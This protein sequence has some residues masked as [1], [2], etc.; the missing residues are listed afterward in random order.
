MESDKLKCFCLGLNFCGF[1]RII[2]TSCGKGGLNPNKS[3]ASPELLYIIEA[4]MNISSES[5]KSEIYLNLLLKVE[6]F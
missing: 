5:N 1:N 2:V 4:Q 3:E 6:N